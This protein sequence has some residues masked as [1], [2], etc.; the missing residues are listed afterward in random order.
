M[1]IRPINKTFKVKRYTYI[2]HAMTKK[3]VDISTNNY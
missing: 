3:E 2:P 1:D